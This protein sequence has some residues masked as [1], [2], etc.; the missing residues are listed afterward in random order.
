LTAI[1]EN[2]SMATIKNNVPEL[3]TQTGKNET[4]RNH[5]ESA[6]GFN[7]FSPMQRKKLSR[8]PV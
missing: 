2:K 3:T 8:V 1:K 5:G 6:T 4:L 7:K